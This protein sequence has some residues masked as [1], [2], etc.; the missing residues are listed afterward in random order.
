MQKIATINTR[1]EPELKSKAEFILHAVGLTSAEAIRLFYTQI[2]LRQGLPFE[3]E[4]PNEKTLRAIH[5]ADTGKTHKAK[6]VDS[7]FETLD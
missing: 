6:S 7:L 1:I 4:I 5:D 2:C 3:V